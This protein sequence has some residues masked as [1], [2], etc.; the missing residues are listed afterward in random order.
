MASTSTYLSFD[1]NTEEAF[2]FYKKI[3]RTEYMGEIFRMSS[4]PPQPGQ[5]ALAEAEQ[6]LI[7]HMALPILGGHV[8]MGTDTSAIMGS[9][10]T[11]GNGMQLNLQPDTRVETDRLFTE[12]SE[13]GKVGYPMKEEFWGDYFGSCT[14]R[15]GVKWMFN[16]AEKK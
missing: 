13:G 7:M 4:V 14:D 5:P 6:N 8:L 12:L 11:F 9:K 2:A 3:F 10:V 16:C 1:R 15:F